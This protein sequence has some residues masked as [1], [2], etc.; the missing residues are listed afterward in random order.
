MFGWLMDGTRSNDLL[1]RCHYLTKA[2]WRCTRGFAHSGSCALKPKWWNF[3]ARLV[4]YF[5]A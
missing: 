4:W 2:G 3:P 1:S 5:G